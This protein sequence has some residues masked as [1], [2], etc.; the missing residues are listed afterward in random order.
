V[1]RIL[2][3][4]RRDARGIRTATRP[5]PLRADRAYRFSS[6]PRRRAAVGVVP[7]RAPRFDVLPDSKGLLLTLYRSEGRRRRRETGTAPVRTDPRFVPKRRCSRSA[8][9]L[10][11]AIWAGAQAL[12]LSD[13]RRGGGRR[14]GRLRRDERRLMFWE[15]TLF[16]F[17]PRRGAEAC[18][19]SAGSCAAFGSARRCRCGWLT[20]PAVG[21]A[22]GCILIRR[23]ARGPGRACSEPPPAPRRPRR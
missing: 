4:R 19:R 6:M 3:P 9:R 21:A 2:G 18:A 1:I 23:R 14:Q 12:R 11:A 5:F 7:K 20:P 15:G 13:S 10:E 16:S 8:L 17:R 22:F